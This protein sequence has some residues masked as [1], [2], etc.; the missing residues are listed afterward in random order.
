MASPSIS[1]TATGLSSTVAA[2]ATSTG[3]WLDVHTKFTKTY[4]FSI[5]WSGTLNTAPTL[6]INISPDG[7]T[8]IIAAVVISGPTGAAGTFSP[9]TP[10][11]VLP[12]DTPQCQAVL[13]N[14][15]ASVSLSV[16]S[17]LSS[18]DSVA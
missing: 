12:E 5:S 8:Q 10:V 2:S 16:V 1:T 15:D 9:W 17:W 13:K 4:H 7:S 14:N 11:I 18:I 6:T 3:S